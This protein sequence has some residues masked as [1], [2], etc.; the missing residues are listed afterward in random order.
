MTTEILCSE[1]IGF[2]RIAISLQ[3]FGLFFSLYSAN[4]I[5][6]SFA[7]FINNSALSLRTSFSL[8]FYFSFKFSKPSA[9]TSSTLKVENSSIFFSLYHFYYNIVWIL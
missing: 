2:S 1:D 3:P 9:S 4:S 6:S 5:S 7:N 8:Y